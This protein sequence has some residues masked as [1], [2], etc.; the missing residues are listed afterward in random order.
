VADV[1][2]MSVLHVAGSD[3]SATGAAML[4]GSGVGLL[5]IGTAVACWPQRGE[6]VSPRPEAHALYDRLY[7]LFRDEYRS[8]QTAF[9]QLRSLGAGGVVAMRT[10]R[11][12]G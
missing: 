3:H 8:Q 10:G 2:G 4:A 6:P 1:L 9:A 11:P 5:D 7:E 12:T